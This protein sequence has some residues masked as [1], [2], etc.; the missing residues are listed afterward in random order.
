LFRDRHSKNKNAAMSTTTMMM[1]QTMRP[2]LRVAS[3]YASR[4]RVGRGVDA[5]TS[6]LAGDAH[7]HES[8]LALSL[9]GEED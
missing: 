7:A 9:G 6:Q 2:S 1:A 8:P 5:A 4:G 3:R